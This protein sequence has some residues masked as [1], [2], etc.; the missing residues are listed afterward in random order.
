[1][2]RKMRQR[3]HGERGLRGKGVTS[4]WAGSGTERGIASTGECI[5]SHQQTG[6]EE[7]MEW[8]GIY[9]WGDSGFVLIS[10]RGQHQKAWREAGSGS[11]RD[12]MCF[13]CGHGGRLR[14]RA[15]VAPRK[16]E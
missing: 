5:E 11:K 12:K 7:G 16:E 6:G 3:R 2:G 13:T 1:M 8:V 10:A 14:W 9:L 15:S 4:A